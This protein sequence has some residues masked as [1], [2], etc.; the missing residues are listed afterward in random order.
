MNKE[1]GRRAGQHATVAQSEENK[2]K[3]HF[4]SYIPSS[5]ET[6]LSTQNSQD[7]IR[8]ITTGDIG[9]NPT[10]G[11]SKFRNPAN[12]VLDPDPLSLSATYVLPSDHT[13]RPRALPAH[14]PSVPRAQN[15]EKRLSRAQAQAQQQLL[16]Q[17]QQQQ[18]NK[19]SAQKGEQSI[20]DL[21]D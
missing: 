16:A 13:V 17:Q 11:R 8:P 1:G 19:K 18:S 3:I 2:R 15:S 12:E 21:W 10:I 6:S 9:L 5:H 4:G 20:T 14:Y 7:H